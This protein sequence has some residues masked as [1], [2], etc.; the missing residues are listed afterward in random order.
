M[1]VN[2]LLEHKEFQSAIYRVLEEYKNVDMIIKDFR[3]FQSAIYRVLEEYIKIKINSKYVVSVSIRYLSRLRR[4]H[5][6][7][8]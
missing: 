8:A 2:H 3:V 7:G 1:L 5:K 4:I 6:L